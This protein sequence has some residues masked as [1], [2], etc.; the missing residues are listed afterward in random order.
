M[1][2]STYNLFAILSSPTPADLSL[3]HHVDYPTLTYS[4]RVR[5]NSRDVLLRFV[6]IGERVHS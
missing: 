2:C 6:L 3:Y 4:T 1:F 5:G